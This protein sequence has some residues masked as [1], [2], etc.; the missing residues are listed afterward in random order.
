MAN[1][2]CAQAS[3]VSLVIL[4]CPEYEVSFGRVDLEEA[5]SS[6]P[7]VP[8]PPLTYVGPFVET[9]HAV[10]GDVYVRDARTLVVRNFNYDG[11]GPSVVF[12]AGEE[13]SLV[14]SQ[15]GE[16]EGTIESLSLSPSLQDTG[17]VVQYPYRRFV[18]LFGPE[19][20]RRIVRRDIELRL[21]DKLDARRLRLLCSYKKKKIRQR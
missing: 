10:A 5:S 17:V 6:S 3:E 8:P 13:D 11:R 4:W 18:G 12:F 15:T 2:P 9:E 20:L 1:F 19:K 14:S 21:P 7:A 16:E